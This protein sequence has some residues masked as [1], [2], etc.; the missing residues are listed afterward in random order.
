VTWKSWNPDNHGVYD[1]PF[2]SDAVWDI[3][4]GFDGHVFVNPANHGIGE[5]DGTEWIEHIGTQSIEMMDIAPDGT[6][7]AGPYNGTE[8]VTYDGATWK[9][10]NHPFNGFAGDMYAL[11][12]DPL[13]DV[14][15]GTIIGLYHSS[16]GGVTWTTFHTGN[17]DLPDNNVFDLEPEPDGSGI[18][19]AT[20]GGL[21]FYDGVTWTEYTMA[22]SGLP[23]DSVDVLEIAPDG[24]LWVGAF[25]GSLW[26]YDGGVARFD[27]TTWRTW[28]EENSNIPHEE[29]YSFGIDASNNV[30]VGTASEGIG[31]LYVEGD[32][33]D[34]FES[35]PIAWRANKGTWISGGTLQLSF[36]DD[37]QVWVETVPK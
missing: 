27:G 15:V 25:D 7:W 13:G 26:P 4:E 10:V 11:A 29:I 3:V 2:A 28:T 31:L 14:W 24:A 32:G 23:A 12:V 18:W 35:L 8:L 36:H 1:W 34:T 37:D 30:W 22:N 5:W 6:L 21:A 20:D 19:I 16:N 9:Q 17:S 33:G